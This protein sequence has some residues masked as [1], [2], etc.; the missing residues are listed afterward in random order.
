MFER[1]TE[2]ARQVVLFAH[3]EALRHKRRYIRTEHLLIGLLRQGEGV[4]SDV[5]DSRA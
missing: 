1:L 2:A 5:L 3:D 4:A